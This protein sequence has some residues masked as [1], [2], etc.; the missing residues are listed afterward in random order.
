MKNI[1]IYPKI[2]CLVDSDP[3]GFRFTAAVRS[4]VKNRIEG[5]VD[6]FT[7]VTILGWHLHAD[8]GAVAEV[9]NGWTV[10]TPKAIVR[11]RVP[12]VTT[13]AQITQAFTADGFFDWAKT[14]IRNRLPG[15]VTVLHWR[16]RLQ[17][18]MGQSQIDE[19]G[20]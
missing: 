7:G 8:E 1:E 12:D 4:A 2:G 15:G 18:G 6:G 11:L 3:T 17:T 20:P 10:Q 16:G 14:G 19:A 13:H 5:I 9:E